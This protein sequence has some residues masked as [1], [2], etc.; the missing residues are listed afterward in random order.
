MT[1]T[2]PRQEFIFENGHRVGKLAQG[3]FPGGTEIEHDGQ[4]FGGMINVLIM[5]DILVRNRDVWD[6]YEVKASTSVK[7]QHKP[8][9]A[10]QWYVIQDQLPLGKA[11]IVHVNSDYEFNGELD[12][13]RPKPAIDE[14]YVASE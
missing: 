5:A 1:P 8:D 10:I 13:A 6:L 4:N 12:R 7:P 9:A 3:L 14:Q 11:H 2:S